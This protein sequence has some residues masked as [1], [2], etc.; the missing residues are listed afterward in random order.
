MVY[1]TPQAMIMPVNDAEMLKLANTY[2]DKNM[3]M[4]THRL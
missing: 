4:Q 1:T 3:C 2:K